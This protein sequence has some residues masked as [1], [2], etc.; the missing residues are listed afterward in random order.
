MNWPFIWQQ[1]LAGILVSWPVFAAGLWVQHRRTVRHV[2]AVTDQ[3]TEIIRRMTNAQT[4]E[5]RD[6]DAGGYQEHGDNPRP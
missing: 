1:A 6:E 5:L 2:D 3:Q 4:R